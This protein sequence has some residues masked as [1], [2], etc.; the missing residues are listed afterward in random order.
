ML[1]G[2]DHWVAIKLF[3]P[4]ASW[5]RQTVMRNAFSALFVWRILCTMTNSTIILQRTVTTITSPLPHKLDLTHKRILRYIN[6][7]IVIPGVYG[8]IN[9]KSEQVMF[10][11]C[12]LRESLQYYAQ[13]L[14]SDPFSDPF[15]DASI[16]YNGM[17]PWFQRVSLYVLD[18]FLGE[19]MTH[20]DKKPIHCCLKNFS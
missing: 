13:W 3:W 15:S 5:K 10:S 18:S 20:T 8:G 17:Q 19:R 12:F 16:L 2:H 11:D 1:I 14:F 7:A 9:G 6:K 4:I